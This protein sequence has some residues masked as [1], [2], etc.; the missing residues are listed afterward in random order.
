MSTQRT[1]AVRLS[2][3]AGALAVGALTLG[4]AQMSACSPYST[5]K[6]VPIDCTAHDGYEF[7]Y[8]ENG[9]STPPDDLV[10]P[11]GN[12]WAAGDTP[13]PDGG[14]SRAYSTIE[15][16]PDG[17]FC[18]SQKADVLHSYY[19]DGRR[20]LRGDLVLGARTRQHDQGLHD[21]AR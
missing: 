17:G 6:D 12:W 4:L 10:S 15:L 14:S 20:S 8:F 9:K 5:L 11:Q 16:I 21:S 2:R 1:S 3:A 7:L 18:G 13:P 19:Y